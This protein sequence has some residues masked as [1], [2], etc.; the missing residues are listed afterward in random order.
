MDLANLLSAELVDHVLGYELS[1]LPD[2]GSP[3]IRMGS[4]GRLF[5]ETL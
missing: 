3:S 4:T 1:H 2:T 5:L